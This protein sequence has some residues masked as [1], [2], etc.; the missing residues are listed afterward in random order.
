MN[1]YFKFLSIVKTN[2]IIFT[3]KLEYLGN[4]LIIIGNYVLIKINYF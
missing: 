2:I 1:K 3:E 4:R